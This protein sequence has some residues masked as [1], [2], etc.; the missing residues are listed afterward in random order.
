MQRCDF[1]VLPSIE[2]TEAFGLVLLEA[3]R[4]GKACICTNVE[5]SGMSNVVEHEKTGLVVQHSDSHALANAMAR[6]NNK[7]IRDSYGQ[8]GQQRFAN[9]YQIDKIEKNVRDLYN[10]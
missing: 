2:R 6:L 5:G 4:A 3:M 8:L 9:A 1:L 7:T 10:E